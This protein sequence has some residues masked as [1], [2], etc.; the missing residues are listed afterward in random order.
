MQ[1]KL[2]FLYGVACHA[3]FLGVY[4]WM[5]AFVGNISFSVIPTI[6]GAREGSLAAAI[7]I[8]ALL[9]ALFGVQH[10]V[11]ARPGFKRWWT[12]FVPQPIERSTYVLLSC[13]AMM[14]L[15]WQWRPMGGVVWHVTQPLA[16]WSLHVL[17][18]LGWLGVPL[19][20]LLINHFDLFGTRQVWLH[21]RGRSYEHLP[22]RTPLAYRVVRHPLYVGWMVAF[23]ATPTMT[24]AH[25]LF[26]ALMTAYIVIAIPLEERDLVAHFGEKYVAY[27]RRVGGLIPRFTSWGEVKL[28]LAI[29]RDMTWWSWIAMIALL[30]ARFVIGGSEPIVAAAVICGGLAII[31]LVRRRGDI[32]A[33][34]VQI[35]LFYT[36][37]LVLGLVPGMGWVHWMQLVGTSIRVLIGYCLLERELRLTPWNLIE[38][39]TWKS[40][41][42]IMTTRPVGG[43]VR[44]GDYARGEARGGACAMARYDAPLES[45]PEPALAP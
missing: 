33:L 3:L 27:R 23:W 18:A 5:A 36:L 21:L 13:L 29:L 39:L 38:H 7:G 40:A 43:L 1:R 17:F 25:L 14:L 2:F 44:F 24:A 30:I 45:P 42:Q 37:L 12:Q 10:S 6:D 19:V 28:D 20:S 31:D 26:A 35:R 15:M 9:I 16:K 32:E 34:S 11:M 8:N 41:W 4:A 22:F